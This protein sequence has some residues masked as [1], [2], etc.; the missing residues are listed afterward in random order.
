MHK[1]KALTNDETL[2]ILPVLSV[3]DQLVQVRNNSPFRAKDI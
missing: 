2:M 1:S 3:L